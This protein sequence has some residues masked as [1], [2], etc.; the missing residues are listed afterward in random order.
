MSFD[1][2]QGAY[3]SLRGIITEHTSGVVFWTG[4]G[5]SAEAGLPTWGKL[6]TTLLKAVNERIDQLEVTERGSLQRTADLIQREP[7]NWQAFRLLRHTLGVTT[8]RALIKES[9]ITSASVEPP[10]LY[11][12]IWLLEPH[13]LLTLN[14]DRLATK[15]YTDLNPGPILTEF[16]GSQI[17]SYSHVLKSLNPFV[18]QLHGDVDDYSS[19]ILTSS[20]LTH[21]LNDTGYR[22]FVTSCL[23]T[24]TVVLVG[25]SADDIAVGGFLDQLSKLDV[26]P[27]YWITHRRDY[28]TNQWAEKRGIRLIHYNAPG[29]DHSELLGAFDDLVS[30]V[31]EDDL[32]DS[33]PIVPEGL[34]PSSE[35]LPNQDDLLTMD[36]ESIRNALN[37]EATRI[38]FSSSSE[39]NQEYKDF[40]IR[41][42]EAIYRAWYTSASP[43]RN[44][45]LGHILH[46][47]IASGA[48]GKVYHASDS[49]GNTVAVKVLHEEMRQDE[50][51]FHA[52]RRGVRSMQILSD[53]DIQGMVPYRKAFEIPAFVVM[54]W[55][56]GPALGDAVASM[57]ISEWELI[58]R[59]GS[60]IAEI[61]RRGH[62]LSE[63][64]L[65]RDICPSN[66]M[67]RGFYTDQQA[68]DVVVL[69]FDLSWHKGALEKS[70]THGATLFG[71]L[72]PEQIQDIPGVSTRHTAVDA[73]GLGMVLYFMLSGKDP[74]PD[75]HL[76]S[77]WYDTLTDM[78][79]RR[80]CVQWVSLPKRFARLINF[81]TLHS[82]AE[83]WDM[84]QIHTELQ[85]LR[86][87]VLNPNSLRSAELVAEEIAARCEFSPEYEWDSDQLSAVA[88]AA[89][90]VMLKIR[91]DESER[92]VFISISWGLPGVQGR[93]HLAKWVEPATVKSC[94]ILSSSGWRIE[95]SR[96]NYAHI[97]ITASISVQDILR[98]MPRT[99]ENLNRALEPVRFAK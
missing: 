81:A 28:V 61:V 23:S 84:T 76:H 36:A 7:N 39:A 1:T 83:R 60:E 52:F 73:F 40:S 8:W 89:S 54:D 27:H 94:D 82:Q 33:V 51:L 53:N 45:L 21:R 87:A 48:F 10:A 44:V 14:L 17:A 86:D 46:E 95:N 19:W 24:K 99:V 26:G 13:G 58:L 78:A 47:E 59:I 32:A 43:E 5:L 35:T 71:Y 55:I 98:D 30:Y 16:V 93:R 96:T 6:R 50:D 2:A 77:G 74:V 79:T 66:V 11:K 92:S 12:K 22:N 88:E 80:P 65:H 70:V 18:C 63:R 91:G 75:Q 85:R 62:L 20:D 38:L 29:G 3:K 72:A 64:V 37:R 67:L 41:Y 42:D 56:D 49:N 68:W 4:S 9:L 34:V 97:D 31:S 25:I 15:S 90:G 57:L 69:D